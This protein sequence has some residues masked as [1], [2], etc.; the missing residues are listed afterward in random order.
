MVFRSPM[1]SSE[2]AFKDLKKFLRSFWIFA[3]GFRGFGV[4]GV[5]IG[6]KRG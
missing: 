4:F 5:W 1:R 3:S 6:M 2:V